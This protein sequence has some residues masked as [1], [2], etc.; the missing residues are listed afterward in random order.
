MTISISLIGMTLLYGSQSTA[1]PRVR[2][3]QEP[4]RTILWDAN[5]RFR[6]QPKLLSDLVN[7]IPLVN[8]QVPSSID[9]DFEIAQSLPNP[10]TKNVAYID[11]FEG[12]L[13]STA[14]CDWQNRVESLKRSHPQQQNTHAATGA[15][16]VV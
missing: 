5:A 3:G 6:M 7:S 1:S 4:T 15:T 2:V 10:N 12:A 16:D 13:N 14:V 11:D 9:M 8:T